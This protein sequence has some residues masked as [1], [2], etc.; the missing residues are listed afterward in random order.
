LDEF[1]ELFKQGDTGIRLNEP[2]A[3]AMAEGRETHETVTREV[4]RPAAEKPSNRPA[5]TPNRTEG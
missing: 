3:E 5:T 4:Q 1:K 2:D